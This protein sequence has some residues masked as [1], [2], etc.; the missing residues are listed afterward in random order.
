M[1]FLGASALLVAALAWQAAS[2]AASYRSLAERVLRDYADFAAV[3]VVRRSDNVLGTYGIGA[4]ARGLARA[5]RPDQPF[6][7]RAAVAA[8]IPE[9]ARRA[10]ELV[11]TLVRI[12]ADG[13]RAE[14]E[15]AAFSAEAVR[16]LAAAVHG[17]P[18]RSSDHLVI[19]PVVDGVAR[20]F[21][22]AIDPVTDA[23]TLGFELRTEAM[24]EW[25]RD[26]ILREPLLPRSLSTPEVT[27]SSL[28]VTVRD[29]DGR[30]LFR[31]AG[32]PPAAQALARRDLGGESGRG[33]L[34][35]FTVDVAIDPSVAESLIIGG[36]PRSRVGWLLALLGVAVGLAWAAFVQMRRDRALAMAR[37]DFVTRASHELRTPVARVRMFTET[38]LLGRVRTDAE[39]R[40]ALLAVDRASRRLSFTIENILRFSPGASGAALHLEAVDL[41]ALVADAVNEFGSA[42]DRPPIHVRCP[43][44]AEAVVDRDAVRHILLNLLDN[45]H[46]YGGPTSPI[47]VE[48]KPVGDEWHVAVQDAGPGV[49]E[50]ERSRVWEPYYRMDRD[51]RSSVAGT[52]IGLAVVR[53]LVGRHH[54]RQWIENGP[55]GGTLVVIAL[56]ARTGDYG[57]AA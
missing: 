11:G 25:F 18:A 32:T 47:Q 53:D 24:A 36:L 19:R 22:V 8:A 3:E 41:A 13:V 38:L 39:Q 46:K 16:A 56:P 27:A 12:E 7:S 4:A 28:Q 1:V 34:A 35:G 44:N 29:P 20:T 14:S 31:S 30:V 55:S 17:A 21:V 50:A 23:R 37:E 40:E 45:A 9:G 5:A 43:P 42:V 26:F 49:P 6:P 57:S 10:T 48:V 51:R 15:D 2:A 33:D 54:G 52:G